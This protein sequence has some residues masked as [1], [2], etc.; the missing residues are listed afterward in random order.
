MTAGAW[1]ADIDGLRALAVVSVI[2]FHAGLGGVTGGY[3]GVDVFF[4]ISG[5]L[6]A[7]NIY[8]AVERG[9]FTLAGFYERRIRRIQPALIA[10]LAVCA[11]VFAAFLTPVDYKSF[12]QSVGASLTFCSNLFFYAKSG[13]F[14]GG[15]ETKPLLH[16]WSLAVEEQYY[17]AFPLLVAALHRVLPRRT[18]LAI[19]LLALLSLAF[20]MVQ[21]RA[22]PDAAFYL[23]FS[24]AWELLAG[25]W[26]ARGALPA[27]RGAALRQACAFAGLLAIVVPVM[28][29]T[30]ATR[31]PGESA[32]LPCLGALLLIHAGSGGPSVAGGWL[33][34]APAAFIGRISYSL[35]LWH[36][37]LLVALRYLLFRELQGPLELGLYAAA[38]VA[39]AWASWRWVEQPFRT[40]GAGPLPARAHVFR[41]TAAITGAGLAFAFVVQA[42]QGFPARFQQPARGYAQAAL[43]TNPQRQRCD[44]LPPERI[45]AGQACALGAAGPDAPSFVLI[46]DSFGDAAAPGIDASARA[47]GR[48][49]LSLTHSGCFLLLGARQ[50]NPACARF[51][52]AATAYVQA[53]PSVHDVLLVGRWTSALLGDRFGQSP[54]PHWFVQDAQSTE[55]SVDENR[56]VFE[57]SLDRLLVALDGRHVAVVAYIPEQR[58][59]VPRALALSATFGRPAQPALPVAMHEQRQEA[60]RD[61]FER[62]RAR[63]PFDVVDVGRALCGP[64]V[65]D[66]LRGGVPLYADDNHLST[67]GAE[68]LS[69]VWSAA[70]GGAPAPVVAQAVS[71]PAVSR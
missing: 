44:R 61:T 54:T 13:Y 35:Y 65:C 64:Q 20:S 48:K 43:D 71:N 46:G 21:V 36:W 50:D 41:A 67:H 55:R 2:A 69:D 60:L 12:A 47:L 15:S 7:G 37:P 31:F 57:R 27:P 63:H 30:P 9:Q 11:V 68:A 42:D 29:Y 22:N 53:H 5:Y 32:L 58:Y 17:L 14:D 62:L 23:P 66:V 6:I 16:T 52:D 39:L 49:G 45:V 56:R 3:V 25:A 8:A 59:D 4:V 19:A 34:S 1:R 38:A 51:M 33:S 40:R 10:M 24:R 28:L 18:T 26:L 70:L